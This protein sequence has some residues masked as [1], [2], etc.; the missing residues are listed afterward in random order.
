[1]IQT[2]TSALE[3]FA[4]APL[5]DHG[6]LPNYQRK[7]CAGRCGN[8]PQGTRSPTDVRPVIREWALSRGLPADQWTR[9]DK[10]GNLERITAERRQRNLSPDS[11]YA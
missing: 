5:V 8:L 6:K 2:V 3:L 10:A 1:L 4:K 9:F 7:V 11:S